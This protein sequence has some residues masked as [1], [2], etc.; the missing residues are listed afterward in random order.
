MFGRHEQKS[1]RKT[2]GLIPK[3]NQPAPT[4]SHYE[5]GGKKPIRRHNSKSTHKELQRWK[6]K[7]LRGTASAKSIGIKRARGDLW[8]F[9]PKSLPKVAFIA[10][11]VFV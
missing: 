9:L 11:Y 2:K 5:S 8:P 6:Y 1:G 10:F 7:Q 3:V 4:L